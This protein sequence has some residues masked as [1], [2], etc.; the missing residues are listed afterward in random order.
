MQ[1][2]LFTTPAA[3]LFMLPLEARTRVHPNTVVIIDPATA[4][5][6]GSISVGTD[7][8]RLALSSDNAYLY[9]G[10]DG[11]NSVQ[12]INLASKTVEATIGLGAS[13]LHAGDIQ[14]MP[15]FSKTVAVVRKAQFGSP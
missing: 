13:S 9:V 3:R 2:K 12:R 6:T 5:V 7:P 11:I 14:V 10:A 1:I 15:G 8:H 4:T